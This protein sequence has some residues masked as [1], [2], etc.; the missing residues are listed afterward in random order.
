MP[1]IKLRINVH[2]AYQEMLIAELDAMDFD[3]FDQE[4]DHLTAWIS[5]Q[6]MNDVNREAIEQILTAYG[7]GAHIES[8]ERGDDRNWNEEW[9]QTIQPMQVGRFYIRPSWAAATE[10]TREEDTERI[11]LEIDPKMSFGTGYHETTRIMLRMMPGVVEQCKRNADGDT[12]SVLDAG[13]GTGILGIAAIKL[14]ASSVF[15][16]DVDEWSSVNTLENVL[17]NGVSEQFTVVQGDDGVIPED[18][19]YD[20]VMANIN[21]NILEDM[22]AKLCMHLRPGGYLMLSGLLESDESGIRNI[23]PYNALKFLKKVQEGEW[24]GLVFQKPSAAK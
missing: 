13:T 1:Y 19:S 3:G 10:S 15:G 12:L 6:M 21:R 24:I 8:E 22:A 23:V 4:E 20:L 16:F 17:L 5:E 11:T 2:S 14:G 9:E 7:D 18:A